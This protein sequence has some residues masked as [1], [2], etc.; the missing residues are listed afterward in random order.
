M[1]DSQYCVILAGGKG[2]RLW[3]CSREA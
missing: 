2:K 3:P 1:S